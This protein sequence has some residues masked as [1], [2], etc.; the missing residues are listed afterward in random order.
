MSIVSDLNHVKEKLNGV[1][2]IGA[3]SHISKIPSSQ[4]Y[5]K[6]LTLSSHIIFAGC[7]A[8]ELVFISSSLHETSSFTVLNC[9][10]FISLREAVRSYFSVFIYLFFYFVG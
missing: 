6:L 8:Q 9:V 10:Y 3:P 5:T 4:F 2:Q 1:L 7:V